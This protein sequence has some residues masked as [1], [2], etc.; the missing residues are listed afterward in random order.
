[1]RVIENNV[2]PFKG[3]TAM[4][5]C[6]L[7]F[8]QREKWNTLSG[9]RQDFILQHEAIHTQGVLEIRAESRHGLGGRSIR[10]RLHN[11]RDI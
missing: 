9:L 10:K 8:V 3:F 2:I 4:N 6:G 7:V 5:I 11:A 1:M